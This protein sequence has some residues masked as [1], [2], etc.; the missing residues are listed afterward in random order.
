MTTIDTFNRGRNFFLSFKC[1]TSTFTLS[2]IKII[3]IGSFCYH[4]FKLWELVVVL[5]FMI[6]ILNPTFMREKSGFAVK[7]LT[8]L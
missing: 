6:K 8:G 5:F 4:F 7:T 2:A 1:Y 3:F